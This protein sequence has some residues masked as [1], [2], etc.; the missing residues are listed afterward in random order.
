MHLCH[1]KRRHHPIVSELG[2]YAM[3]KSD[4]IRSGHPSMPPFAGARAERLTFEGGESDPAVV[5]TQLTVWPG[6]R[7]RLLARSSHHPVAVEW[8]VDG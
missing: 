1:A 4:S 5:E 8:V 7:R 6:G 3:H 2:I